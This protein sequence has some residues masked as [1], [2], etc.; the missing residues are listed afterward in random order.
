[1]D[2]IFRKNKVYNQKHLKINLSFKKE[3]YIILTLISM[4]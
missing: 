1:M 2:E 4:F 3:T